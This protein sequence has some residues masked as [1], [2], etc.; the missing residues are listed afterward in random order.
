MTNGLLFAH[1]GPL[2]Q[3]AYPFCAK[4]DVETGQNI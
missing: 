2:V 4:A 3:L 1:S